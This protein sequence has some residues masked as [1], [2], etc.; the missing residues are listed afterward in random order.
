MSLEVAVVRT[1]IQCAGIMEKGEGASKLDPS[2]AA[3]KIV[4]QHTV[5]SWATVKT[6]R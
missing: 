1:P 4:K 2:S 6:S 5:S 3:N